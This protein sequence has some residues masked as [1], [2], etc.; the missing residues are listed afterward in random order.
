MAAHTVSTEA[1]P[2][3]SAAVQHEAGCWPDQ[4]EDGAGDPEEAAAR[5]R[6]KA[7]ADPRFLAGLK[8]AAAVVEAALRGALALPVFGDALGGGGGG[9]WSA[10]GA[11]AG[12][13][14]PPPSAPAAQPVPLP[15]PPS[16]GGADA[17][18]GASTPSLLRIAGLRPPGPAAATPVSS[19]AWSPDGSAKVRRRGRN[20][21]E[22]ARA[23]LNQFSHLSL[24]SH[25]SWLPTP[26]WRTSRPW[27]WAV[28]ALHTPRLPP[29]RPHQ[30]SGGTRPA[31]RLGRSRL[32]PL[33]PAV[34]RPAAR[35]PAF[36]RSRPHPGRRA[37]LW[38]G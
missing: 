5:F 18:A 7:E 30:P 22:C 31:R 16:P 14:P 19:L 21:H 20:G 35:R 29:L 8:G 15:L 25:S 26:T 37:C 3:T 27:T 13:P 4:G 12:V 23:L 17:A 36:P 34:G 28:A 32:S 24:L 1:P 38:R 10:G 6:R 2:T 9:G 33:H 11:A